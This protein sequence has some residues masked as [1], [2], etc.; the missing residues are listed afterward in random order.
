M[1]HLASRRDL[2][3]IASV[4]SKGLIDL[5]LLGGAFP[6]HTDH[7]SRHTPLYRDVCNSGAPVDEKMSKLGQLM[8]ESHASCRWVAL[9]GRAAC[10]FAA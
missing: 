5:G 10:T 1:L 7:C 3:T 6:S 4:Y 8:D 9:A 2:V